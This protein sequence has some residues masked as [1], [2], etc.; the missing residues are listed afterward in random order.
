MYNA[1][2]PEI[3]KSASSAGSNSPTVGAN[4]N[5]SLFDIG[6]RLDQGLGV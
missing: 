5:I 3:D 1:V 6:K 2:G 4:D